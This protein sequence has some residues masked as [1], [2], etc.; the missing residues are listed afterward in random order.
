ME[1]QPL[2]KQFLSKFVVVSKIRT[3]IKKQQLRFSDVI[4]STNLMP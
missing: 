4:C 1:V 2:L 3:K